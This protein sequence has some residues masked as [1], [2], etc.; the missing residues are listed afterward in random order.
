MTSNAKQTAQLPVVNAVAQSDRLLVVYQASNS[1]TAQTCTI[2]VQNYET[3]TLISDPANSTAYG[4]VT[5][6]TVLYSANFIYVCDSPNH[7]KR[8][9]LSSF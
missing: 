3:K 6:G 5:Q 9:A 7:L 1:S 2:S 8:V 4:V